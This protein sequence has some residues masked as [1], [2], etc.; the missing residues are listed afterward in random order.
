MS[1]IRRTIYSLYISP[2]NRKYL[3]IKRCDP[4]TAGD[5]AWSGYSREYKIERR[6]E[7]VENIGRAIL[8]TIL[9]GHSLFVGDFV[10]FSCIIVQYG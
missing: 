8:H 7:I 1:R 4:I 6:V 2:S 9:E 10:A 5:G 3:L